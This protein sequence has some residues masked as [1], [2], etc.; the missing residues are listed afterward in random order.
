MCIRKSHI[1]FLYIMHLSPITLE[2][3]EK[4]KK[5]DRRTD[6]PEPFVNT[7]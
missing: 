3:N 6:R 7:E 1:S 5:N 2:K 4:K